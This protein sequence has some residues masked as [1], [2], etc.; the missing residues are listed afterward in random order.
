MK[1][2]VL[3]ALAFGGFVLLG[4]LTA[5]ADEPPRVLTTVTYTS[6]VG[7]VI[8][9]GP[10][11]GGPGPA[12]L[13][14]IAVPL[15]SVVEGVEVYLNITMSNWTSDL[16]VRLT[17]PG[18]KTLGVAGLGEGGIPETNIIGW[19]PGDFVPH[20]DLAQYIGEY[21]EGNWVLDCR[22]YSNGFVGTLN[23]WQLRVRYDDS[24]PTYATSFSGIKA[25]FR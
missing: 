24:V 10:A 3:L 22:D 23:Q 12:L 13:N 9:D 25:L 6:N 8:P 18:V 17:S 7:Q 14:T 1:I 20:D 19:F 4:G 16:I 11:G 21:T 5:M 15:R 2:S